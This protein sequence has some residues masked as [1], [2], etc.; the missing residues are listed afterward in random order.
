MKKVF[1]LMLAL[2]VATGMVACSGGEGEVTPEERIAANATTGKVSIDVVSAQVTKDKDGNDAVVVTYNF[3]NNTD[4][5]R[6]FKTS[7]DVSANQGAEKLKAAIVPI[8]DIYKDSVGTKAIDVGESL[9]VYISYKL[10]DTTTPLSVTCNIKSGEDKA[11]VE[12]EVPLT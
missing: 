1:A 10:I 7:V 4:K 9:E 3:T 2:V 11:T 12:K 5:K 6:D 8:G